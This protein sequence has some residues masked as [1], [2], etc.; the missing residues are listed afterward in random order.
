MRMFWCLGLLACSAVANAA[1]KADLWP[2]WQ[3]HDATSTAT[4]SYTEW[5]RLLGSYVVAGSDGVNRVAYSRVSAADKAALAAFV[6]RLEALPISRYAQPAAG[7][8]SI[9]RTGYVRRKDVEVA[10][11]HLFPRLIPPADF[12]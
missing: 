5:D 4:V 6:Q 2:R 9:I 7:F 1:P 3:A 12:G 11:H 8:R 10:D